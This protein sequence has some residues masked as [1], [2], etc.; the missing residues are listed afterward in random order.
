M[1]GRSWLQFPLPT[2]R[3]CWRTRSH[4]SAGHDLSPVVSRD[5]RRSKNRARAPWPSYCDSTVLA[6]TE[7][8]KKSPC[9]RRALAILDQ[10]HYGRLLIETRSRNDGWR[11]SQRDRRTLYYIPF[12]STTTGVSDGST[13]ET[14]SARA[15]E[16][17]KGLPFNLFMTKRDEGG[18][19]SEVLAREALGHVDRHLLCRGDYRLTR[20][21][22]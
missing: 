10:M 14:R 20:R 1:D 6:R 5:D 3:E 21:R 18:D 15:A 17:P 7:A 4:C 16:W 2:N 11:P 22:T 19:D 12:E 8:P 9:A 13:K